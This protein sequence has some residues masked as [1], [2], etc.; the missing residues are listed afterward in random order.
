[1][2]YPVSR[3]RFQSFFS[4]PKL[5]FQVSGLRVEFGAKSGGSRPMM[6]DR[7]IVDQ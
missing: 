5:I 1:M 7:K 6:I 4:V 2:I 3:L